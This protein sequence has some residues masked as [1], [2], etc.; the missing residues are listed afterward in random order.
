MSRLQ[1]FT[2][3]DENP[4]AFLSSSLYHCVFRFLCQYVAFEAD[5]LFWNFQS[6]IIRRERNGRCRSHKIVKWYYLE[7]TRSLVYRIFYS[8]CTRLL[9][10]TKFSPCIAIWFTTL[11][12]LHIHLQQNTSR[13]FRKTNKT[14]I[15]LNGFLSRNRLFP[16]KLQAANSF[17]VGCWMYVKWIA[18][19]LWCVISCCRW[20]ERY[21][22]F[23]YRAVAGL[24]RSVRHTFAFNGWAATKSTAY[25]AISIYTKQFG[26]LVDGCR[27]FGSTAALCIECVCVWSTS[28]EYVRVYV[29]CYG[30]GI[31]TM[32]MNL[33]YGI[34]TYY[35]CVIFYCLL[36]TPD[37]NTKW[38]IC[39]SQLSTEFDDWMTAN[40]VGLI[41]YALWS[42]YV[43]VYR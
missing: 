23:V 16:K 7:L 29:W 12:S 30:D 20:N 17:T 24:L 8:I 28:S 38:A 9:T 27:M 42:L 33:R 5:C 4:D 2:T 6:T 21:F 26:K 35:S 34:I 31:C 10:I 39:E 14:T 15:F 32:N 36:H 1:F 41:C 3:C 40:V 11:K 43:S 22:Y 37:Q 13:T 25:E 19:H 18:F